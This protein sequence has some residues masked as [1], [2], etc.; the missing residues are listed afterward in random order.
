MIAW[1]VGEGCLPSR[2]V[3]R[4]PGAP[5]VTRLDKAFDQAPSTPRPA[6]EWRIS[7]VIQAMIRRMLVDW[8][9]PPLQHNTYLGL[10]YNR[11][12]QRSV[13]LLDWK[14]TCIVFLIDSLGNAK[15][16]P[17]AQGCQKLGGIL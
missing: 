16:K 1:G 2:A 7:A 15:R 13:Q 12:I 4:A 6:P 17:Q 11:E 3:P 9:E 5:Q 14:A 10:A 8:Q